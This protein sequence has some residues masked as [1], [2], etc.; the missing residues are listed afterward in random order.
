MALATQT[1][2][3]D[4]ILSGD[5]SGSYNSP[6]LSYTGVSPG[7]YANVF[8][9]VDGKGRLSFAA[10][11]S[12]NLGG[13][14][15][16][17]N[18]NNNLVSS[19]VTA[20]TYTNP[21]FTVDAKG[22]ITSASSKSFIL[23]GDATGTSSSNTLN[24]TLANSGVAS[25]S[26]KHP[27]IT[28]DA[29]GRITSAANGTL[30]LTGDITGS[31]SNGTI[32]TT[33]SSTGVTAGTYNHPA[34][35]IDTKGRI[36]AIS[37]VTYTLAGDVS[38]STTGFA[39]TTS[40]INS[41]VTA[42]TYTNPTFTVDA[43][44]RIT[45]ATSNVIAPA[46]YTTVGVVSVF[47]GTP[48]TISNGV[49]NVGLA[50]NTAF[51]VVKVYTADN[52]LAITNGVLSIGTNVP[53]LNAVNVFTGGVFHELNTLTSTSGTIPT[54][55]SDSNIRKIVLT[56]NATLSNPTGMSSGKLIIIIQ[57]GAT[58]YTLGYGTAFK[59]VTGADKNISTTPNSINILTCISDGTNLWCTLAKD[60]V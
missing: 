12:F 18:T 46:T 21:T 57:Q 56:G 31:S 9:T 38:G 48:L 37:N 41:G 5:L 7:T 2:A 6:S 24:V 47:P 16:G 4:I 45:A 33:L 40:L 44:G 43:K 51:G 8:I 53:K 52:T 60:F 14:L 36:T 15:T 3:G 34:I 39:M 11:G 29:K 13:D 35:T 50:S 55:N 54:S 27:T 30:A 32:A 49:L 20:G 42:G 28:V 10:N 23:T 22:R 58:P 25:G 17:T 19:G 1:I 59:F 26:Y